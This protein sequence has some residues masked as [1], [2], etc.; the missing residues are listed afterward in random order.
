MQEPKPTKQEKEEGEEDAPEL[1]QSRRKM[2]RRGSCAWLRGQRVQALVAHKRRLVE[3][4][5]TATLSHTVNVLVAN[6]IVAVPVAAP[7]GRWIGAGGSMILESDRATGAVR[8]QYIGMVTMLDVL[9]HVAEVVEGGS[10]SPKEQDL[11]KK[12]SVL[13]CEVIG[14]SPEGLS[15]WTLH[16]NTS[17]LD[18]MET[19]SKGVHRALVPLESH[20]ENV[21]A[22][23]L[24][25]ASPGYRMLTQMDV[26]AFL[27][28]HAN[29]LKDVISSSV[30]DLGAVN[31]NVFAVTKNMKVIEAIKSMRLVSDLQND[32]QIACLW[33]PH[34]LLKNA[35]RM[36]DFLG[37]AAL[38]CEI[39]QGKGKRLVDTFSATDLRGCSVAELQTWLPK[40]VLQFK[41]KV[42]SPVTP[43]KLVTCYHETSLGEVID[44]AVQ[45]RVHRVWVVDQQGML[46]GIVSLTDMLRVIREAVL[47]A[48]RELQ[49][50]VSPNVSD[51]V[52]I[53]S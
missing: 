41:Q 9:V 16:H 27:A 21:I 30:H 43:R 46:K 18:C 50:V 24:T 29:E 53:R 39:L 51:R 14:H 37:G 45:A 20:T 36:A 10:A 7:P 2:R 12:M 26:L 3:V 42:S 5:Y 25:E 49:R 11:E 34:Q 47:D 35:I 23:E 38:T 33:V 8:K 22:T 48:D 19:F 32:L 40:N 44:E 52:A 31:D 15:L 6:N 13:V 1:K 17:I 28:E 4:P